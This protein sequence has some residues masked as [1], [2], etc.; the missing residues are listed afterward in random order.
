MSDLTINSYAVCS[1]QG[2]M[3]FHEGGYT[4]HFYANGHPAECTCKGYHFRK[5]CR[6]LIAADDKCCTWHEAFDEP[7][8]EEGKCPKCGKP[9]IYVN[10]AV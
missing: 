2:N 9:V 3:V 8:T 4:Q 5:T 6:H 1:D 10:M 7:M